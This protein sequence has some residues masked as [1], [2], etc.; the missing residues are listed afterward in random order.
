MKLRIKGDSLRLRLSQPETRRIGDGLAVHET[1][2]FPGGARL[3][4]ALEPNGQAREIGAS[5]SDHRLVISLPTKL[6][7][8]WAS[9]PEVSLRAVL[10]LHR[11]GELHVL[12]EKDFA[13]L[14]PRSSFEDESELFP[15]PHEAHGHCR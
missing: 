12:I 7:L 1:T 14:K 2:T 13:C 10:P 9:G 3:V 11:G 15:N 6:G 8:A 5:F 4:Y